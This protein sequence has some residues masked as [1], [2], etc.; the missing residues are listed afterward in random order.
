MH[1]LDLDL[2]RCFL[3][4]AD[5][6]NFTAA[7][8]RLGRSQSAVSVRIRKLEEALGGRLFQ[9]NNQ[10]V[11]LTDK[12]RSLLP[13][14]K[15]L[16]DDSER[17]MAVM[18]SPTVSGKLRI[19]FLEYVAPQKFPDLLNAIQRQLPEAELSF[20]VGL[21]SSLKAAL[22]AGELDLTLALHD[23]ESET[24]TVIGTDP[25]VWVEGPSANPDPDHEEDLPLCLMQ[26]PCIY[27]Q[28][29]TAVLTKARR[30]YSEVLTASSVQAV[31]NAV[32]SGFGYSVLG[33]SCLGDGVQPARW[34]QNIAEL[35]VAT[36]ALHG[37]DQRKSEVETV[38]RTV[39]RDQLHAGYSPA[40]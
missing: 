11:L 18:Q 5:E 38:F 1:S 31:R 30:G 22:R 35:P 21:S 24:S 40:D 39:F 2:L 17:L 10:D 20:R 26:S 29:A 36:L 7:G 8:V 3:I 32:S 23:P 4:V 16:L 27:R 37:K 6:R 13:L 19:G 34:L 28:A 33:T 15:A 14:A 12:G 25:L 9:R